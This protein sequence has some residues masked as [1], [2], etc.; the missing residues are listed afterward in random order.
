L[1]K[2]TV[3]NAAIVGKEEG[4]KG[5]KGWGNYGDTEAGEFGSSAT[6]EDPPPLKRHFIVIPVFS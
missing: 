5:A 2:R 3:T 6:R 4:K 1:G